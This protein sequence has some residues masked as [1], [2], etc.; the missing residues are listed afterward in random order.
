MK[1]AYLINQYPKVSHSF[2]RQEILALEALGIEVL[3]F[4]IRSCAEELVDP[5]DQKELD[6]TR[7][8]LAQGGVKLL[9]SLLKVALTKPKNFWQTSILAG[10]IGW[11]SERGLLIHFIYLAEACVLL[12][13]L[14]TENISHLH[15][16]FGTNSTTVAMFCNSLGDCPYSFTVHGPEEFDKV[17]AISLPEKIHRAKFVVAIS[18]FTRSQLYR[19][20]DYHHWSKIRLIHCGVDQSF[21]TPSQVPFPQEAKFVCVG[22]LSE[23]KGHLLLLE[24]VH[25]LAQKGLK[26]KIVFVGD[27]ELRGE[28]EQ[29]ISQYSLENYITITG[30]ASN[31]EVRQQILSSQV[32]LLPSFAEGLPVVIM[33]A[34]ALARPV[35]STYI[36]GIPE[37]VENGYHGWLI[38]SGSIEELTKIMKTALQSSAEELEKMGKLGREKVKQEHNQTLEARKL[39]KL[40]S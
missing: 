34:F 27:G 6:K 8:V 20:C 25:N 24:A 16:H 9:L 33:E 23:Q 2:I 15:S 36:A 38:P 22:R 19:W 3:R 4:A 14:K 31:E 11:G 40:F 39:L 18:S 1:I 13:W 7:Y 26:F 28:I 37:L 5:L 30:W 29:K 12:D 32:L 35:I 17:Q 10:K 21:L